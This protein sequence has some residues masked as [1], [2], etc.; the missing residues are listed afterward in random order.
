[1]TK[2]SPQQD[3]ALLAVR[4]WLR[5]PG[6]KQW[7]YLAGYAG[8]GKT[9]LAMALAEAVTGD[10]IFGAYTGIAAL[11]M[12]SKGC[13]GAATLHSLIYRFDEAGWGGEPS[14]KLNPISVIKDAGLVIVDEVSMVDEALATDLLSFGTR[15]LVLGDPEQLPPVKGEG[16]FTAREPDFMLT[17]VHRQALD[18]P[19]VAMSMDVREGRELKRG[20][21]GASRVISVDDVTTEAVMG[22]DQ[23]IVGRN[24]TRHR[25]N[26]RMRKL[27][28]FVGDLPNQ[29]ERL[30]CLRNNRK[31][32]LFNGQIWTAHDAQLARQKD[33][34]LHRRKPKE[35][36]VICLSDPHGPHKVETMAR[37]EDFQGI[38]IDLPW[39]KIRKYDRFDYGYAI[40]AHKAQGS[41]WDDV[42]IFDESGLF[43]ENA[44]RWLYTAITRAADRVTVVC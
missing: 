34:K 24:A 27:H 26:A 1:M 35:D 5:D 12:A 7:F 18:N 8:T 38:E 2:W 40:T 21:Y 15:V 19:I 28:G 22:A 43:R 31:N 9:T 39:E 36:V 10:V 6:G 4:N 14:F 23:V 44:T 17:E 3:A 42:F 37:I 33:P 30:I 32:G 29:G 41:Q 13:V 11:V 16:Y 25:Y 20:T